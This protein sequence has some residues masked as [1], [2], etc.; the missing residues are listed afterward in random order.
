MERVCIF[1][2]NGFETIEALT[3]IDYLR[4]AC[5]EKSAILV[6]TTGD[7]N[8]TSAQGVIIKADSLIDELDAETITAAII[9]GGLPGATNFWK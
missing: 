9:P 4:R 6:S 7:L 5:G 3:P 2:A 1:L 8:V